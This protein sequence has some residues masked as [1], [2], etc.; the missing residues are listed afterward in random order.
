MERRVNMRVCLQLQFISDR[1]DLFYD[2]EWTNEACFRA[3][4]AGYT[5]LRARLVVLAGRWV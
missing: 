3:G 1:V 4:T 2:L 5:R